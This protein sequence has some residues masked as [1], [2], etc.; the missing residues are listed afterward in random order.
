M[1]E[2][3]ASLSDKDGPLG[4]YLR[5]HAFKIYGWKPA[6]EEP[7]VE[8]PQY[9]EIPWN[10]LKPFTGS[11]EFVQKRVNGLKN[12]RCVILRELMNV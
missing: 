1:P 4:P 9:E 7:P 6:S 3:L 10:Y 11:K 12:E 2:W 5:F 8:P